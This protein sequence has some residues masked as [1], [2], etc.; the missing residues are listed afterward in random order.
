M[1]KPKLVD[2]YK[3]LGQKERL[4]EREIA[5]AKLLVKASNI[6]DGNIY[7]RELYQFSIYLIWNIINNNIV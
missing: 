3:L 5:I 4:D 7:I 2:I 1:R 6:I